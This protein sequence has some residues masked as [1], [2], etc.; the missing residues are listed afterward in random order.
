ML[1]PA[2]DNVV[3]GYEIDNSLRFNDNDSAYL[4]RTP[5]SAGNR[6]TWTWAG[7]VKRGNIDVVYPTMFGSFTNS[8]NYFVLRF[9]DVTDILTVINKD[10]GTNGI[11]LQT[12]AKYRDVSG[13]YHVVLSVDTTQT[14][15]SNR[16]K[17]Y[18]NGEQVTSFSGET[19][20]SQN[21]DTR[22]N[23]ASTDH[24][25]GNSIF[26]QPFDGYLSD[27][28]F[29]DGQALTPDSFGETGA[30]G[31]F[32]TIPYSGTYGTNGFY[33]D[34]KDAGS[35]GNDV[36]GNNNDW[37][38]HNL[39]ATDQMLD[40]PTNNFAVINVLD[41]QPTALLTAQEGNLEAALGNSIAWRSALATF[42]KNSGKIYFEF[43][44]ATTTG[45]FVGVGVDRYSYNGNSAYVGST[46]ESWSYLLSSGNKYTNAGATAYGNAL[47]VGDVLGC[48][49]DLDNGKLFFAKNGVWQNSA[50]PVAGTGSAFTLPLGD[51]YSFA[52]SGVTG[53]N[54]VI[55]FGQDSSFAGNKT[56]QGNADD[57]GIGDFYYSPPA[58]YLALCTQNLPDAEVIPSEHFNTVLY[59]GTGATQSITG[60]G[61]E[62]DWTWVKKRGGNA[63]LE[64]HWMSDSVRG[65]TKHLSSSLTD[66]EYTFA[67]SIASLDSDGFTLGANGNV[68][69][70]NDSF[71]SWNWKANGS[72]VANTDGSITSTVSANV[73]AGFSIVGYTGSAS[74]E[75]VGHGL[76]QAPDLII[77]K[78]RD[79]S[80]AWGVGHE[81]I[82]WTKY[83][84]LNL[85]NAEATGA[86]F[87]N[88][89]PTSSVFSIGAGFHT[90]GNNHIAYCFHS[91]EGYSKFGSYTGNGSTDGAFVHCGFRP[92]YVMVKRTDVADNWGVYDSV[93]GDYNLNEPLLE[94]NNSDA[95][96][97]LPAFALDF[98]SNGI[99][100]RSDK[101]LL[102]GNGANYIFMA[103]AEM[104]MVGGGTAR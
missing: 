21:Y 35:L 6:K 51:D 7:W 47:A 27:V 93:R 39:A 55:N 98:V 83:L 64:N 56:A 22:V 9:D 1:I 23:L 103:F 97:N 84:H 69:R 102:N 73:A 101:N 4:S 46:S 74:A 36:S 71:V 37:T 32:K 96:Y 62:T 52:F 12:N 30:Y 13:W 42:S 72:G 50:D 18:I 40:T 53:G 82:G 17:L 99:K 5:A 104:P 78:D 25:I 26:S 63:S 68:N 57:N 8:T 80:A 34:F 54:G 85:T 3:K 24:R 49:V 92:A 66:A 79:A 76:T 43:S 11:V 45:V 81:S 94:P 91:V 29:I 60:I 75:T 33:L 100:I 88:A 95:E 65:D 38:S 67:D 86:R 19:Y 87:N 28:H 59:S 14:T 15:S 31:E 16:A 20:P 61:F 58:G 10:G 70:L 44:S 48:A 41:T 90:S 77:Y 2:T 89:A